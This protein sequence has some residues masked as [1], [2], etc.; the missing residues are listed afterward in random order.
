[1]SS[2]VNAIKHSVKPVIFYFSYAIVSIFLVLFQPYLVAHLFTV[3]SIGYFVA[4]IIL[5]IR[6]STNYSLFIMNT[7]YIT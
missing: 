5:D 3:V 4:G 6:K 1:M 7:H 2:I